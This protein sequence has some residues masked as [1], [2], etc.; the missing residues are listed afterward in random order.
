MGKPTFQ[1]TPKRRIFPSAIT[2]MKNRSQTANYAMT[3]SL[4]GRG[5]LRLSPPKLVWT[6]PS[7]LQSSS[8]NPPEGR[9]RK[10]KNI[11]GGD[12]RD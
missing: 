7:P 1:A 3:E 4:E 11:K 10:M 9:Q 5:G 12:E 6:F 2:D 8:T